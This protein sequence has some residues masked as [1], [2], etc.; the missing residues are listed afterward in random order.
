MHEGDEAFH[1]CCYCQRE[2]PKLEGSHWRRWL[3][4]ANYNCIQCLNA[5]HTRISQVSF[6][7]HSV[8]SIPPPLPSINPHIVIMVISE[9]AKG[10][11]RAHD[12]IQD[13]LEPV[14]HV[15]E[16]VIRFTEAI[17]DLTLQLR[18][19]EAIRDIKRRESL[20]RYSSSGCT[21]ELHF[22]YARL[23]PSWLIAG[24]V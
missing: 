12:D 2:I 21:S 7:F 4:S 22:R 9:K 1:K 6:L 19:N 11:Q 15:R 20:A 17:P 8:A 14:E 23:E 16:L 13:V 18:P 24:C 5:M 3:T 10:K